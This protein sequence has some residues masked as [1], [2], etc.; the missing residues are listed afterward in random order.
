MPSRRD[1]RSPQ[2]CLP[3]GYGAGPT[4]ANAAELERRGL[5]YFRLPTG[6]AAGRGS[7]GIASGDICDTKRGVLGRAC[8]P[9]QDMYERKQIRSG[10]RPLRGGRA[11]AAMVLTAATVIA[12]LKRVVRR[13]G[14]R[15]FC[16]RHRMMARRCWLHRMR[17]RRLAHAVHVFLPGTLRHRQRPKSR[18]EH[19]QQQKPSSPARNSP[20]CGR[21]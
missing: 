18:S 15:C 19:N 9:N 12:G 11:A 4:N 14:L 17:G 21:A 8:G 7:S 10:M 13:Y 16:L 6:L 2:L 3:S 20:H 1:L 5:R